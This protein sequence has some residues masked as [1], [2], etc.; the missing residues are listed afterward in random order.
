MSKSRMM[1]AGNAGSSGY[2]SNVNARQ[3]GGN[4]LQGLNVSVGRKN[5][6]PTYYRSYG[7]TLN[8]NMVFSINQLGGGVGKHVY[9][10]STDAAR[11]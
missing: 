10:N 7:T 1:G 11:K 5:N 6:T 8:R 3:S 9:S 2:G 4:A